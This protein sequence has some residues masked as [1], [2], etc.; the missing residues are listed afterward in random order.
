VTLIRRGLVDRPPGL[1]RGQA[2][3]LRALESR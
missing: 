3:A 1:I 2:E